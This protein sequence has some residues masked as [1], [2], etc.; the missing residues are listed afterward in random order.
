MALGLVAL[1]PATPL[2]ATTFAVQQAGHVVAHSATISDHAAALDLE[3]ADGGVVRLAIHG[4]HLMV[5][6]AEVASVRADGPVSQAWRELV[7]GAGALNPGE[8][9]T[10]LLRFDVSGLEGS[11][12]D[13]VRA[14][15]E[16]ARPLQGA[17]APRP[18]PTVA[19][20]PALS[21]LSAQVAAAL[22]AAQ[23]QVDLDGILQGE[24]VHTDGLLVPAGEV[25]DGPVTVLSGD[26]RVAGRIRGDLIALG[27]D[28]IL[29]DGGVV[30]GNVRLL[31]GQLVH[32][33]GRVLGRVQAVSGVL[34]PRPEVAPPVPDLVPPRPQIVVS[35]GASAA[36]STS[37]IGRIAVDLL[38][39][40]ASFV[41]LAF[42]GIGLMFFAPRQL[43]AVADTVWHSFWRSFLAGLFAQPLL[44][45]ALGILIVG[46]AITLVGLLVVPFAVAAFAVALFLAVAGGYIAVARTV[47]EIYVRRRMAQ[48]HEV[49]GWLTYRY[50]FYGLLGLLAIWIPAVLLSWVP[51]AGT[52]A[53][54]M[55]AFLTWMV[56]TA[57]FGA[58]IVS[59]GGV[60]GTVIRQID[61]ALTDEHFWEPSAQLMTR[62]RSSRRGSE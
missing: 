35:T 56:A 32:N 16:A 11:E 61:Q 42:L 58:T 53:L 29:E 7:T 14:I 40:I 1:L 48:G 12:A 62:S 44:L 49:R 5:N 21:S 36:G 43:E 41:G 59:R 54:I 15:R 30:D 10:R 57:G 37:A 52:I 8:L 17:Q 20:V 34:T 2:H 24:G 55:A 27:G 51:V 46:L 13:A 50:L 4:D 3:L 9:I 31:Q 25:L 23:I 26:V 39:L 33:G 28:V 22:E 18:A 38:S 60:R 19:P 45:P 6:G 47:G